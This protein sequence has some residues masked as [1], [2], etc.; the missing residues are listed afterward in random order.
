MYAPASHV[1]ANA[2]R[3]FRATAVSVAVSGLAVRHKPQILSRAGEGTGG[4]FGRFEASRGRS[5]SRGI[6]RR[7]AE[8]VTPFSAHH[9]R[10]AANEARGPRRCGT[11]RTRKRARLWVLG[12]AITLERDRVWAG[13]QSGCPMRSPHVVIVLVDPATPKPLTEGD[14]SARIDRFPLGTSPQRSL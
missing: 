14:C 2:M 9:L 5:C 1:G 4:A 3:L 11:A 10:C 6:R 7:H 12:R 13:A 8:R